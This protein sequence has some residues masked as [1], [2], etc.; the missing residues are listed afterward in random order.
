MVAAVTGKQR[1]AVAALVKARADVDMPDADGMTA[2]HFA[3]M[4][5]D[6][7]T[8]KLLVNAK[9]AVCQQNKAG[10]SPLELVRQKNVAA[11]AKCLEILEEAAAACATNEV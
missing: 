3:A 1:K 11:N 9:A 5:L 7:K 10:L 6:A 8:L 2:T 4:N